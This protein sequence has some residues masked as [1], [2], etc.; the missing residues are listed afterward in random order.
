MISAEIDR[1]NALYLVAISR[2]NSTVFREFL[3]EIFGKLIQQIDNI[4]ST[5][6]IFKQ[7]K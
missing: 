3:S 2:Q 7:F 5:N 1:A 4:Q 6:H